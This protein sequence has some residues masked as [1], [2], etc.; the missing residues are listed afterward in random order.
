MSDFFI[1][2]RFYYKIANKP[3]T[4]KN[5]RMEGFDYFVISLVY[6]TF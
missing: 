5:L 2:V 4:I 1:K 3:F 6:R